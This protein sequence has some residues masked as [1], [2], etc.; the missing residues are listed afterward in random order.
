[1]IQTRASADESA[2]IAETVKEVRRIELATS[3][4]V[5][6]LFAGQY[7][8]AFRGRGLEFAEVREYDDSDDHRLIDWSVTARTGSLHVRQYDEERELTALLCVDISRSTLFGTGSALKRDVIVRLCALMAFA[9][10]RN[11]DRVGA[12]LVSDHPEHFL[13]PRKGRNHMLHL[14]RDV[15]FVE[16]TADG[17]N[18]AAGL[19]FVLRVMRKR[20][21]VFVLSDFQCPDFA[22]ELRVAA[23]RHD[24]VCGIV[25][26]PWEIELPSG[27][28]LVATRDPET[29]RELLLDTNSPRVVRRYNR[30]RENH[31]PALARKMRESGAEAVTFSTR[32]D[33]VAPLARF[34]RRRSQG[35][36]RRA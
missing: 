27:V 19:E 20:A 14:V 36:R 33:T 13:A 8:S 15:L 34:F 35:P 2:R 31:L 26:D 7:H 12:V 11:N 28:G 4:L 25:H 32:E 6:S 3:R 1:M 5:D 22:K 23:L 30:D 29:G 10:M 17:T 16:P 9:A 21:I 24:V 18:I